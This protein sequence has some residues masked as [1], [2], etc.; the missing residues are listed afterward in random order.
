VNAPTTTALPTRQLGIRRT[1]DFELDIDLGGPWPPLNATTER[2]SSPPHL[3]RLTKWMHNYDSRISVRESRATV[4]LYPGRRIEFQRQ[5]NG[6]LLVN[7]EQFASID[8]RTHLV[9]LLRRP[10]QRILTFTPT[11]LVVDRRPNGNALTLRRRRGP[12]ISDGL[13]RSSVRL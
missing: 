4:R 6:W 8:R 7:A 1:Y 10:P 2:Y 12:E 5:G 13:G 3:Q 11:G 9:P